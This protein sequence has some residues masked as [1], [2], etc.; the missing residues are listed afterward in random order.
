MNRKIKY[1]LI[2]ASGRLG[3]EVKTVFSEHGHKLVFQFDVKGEKKEDVPEILIDCSLPEVLSKTIFYVNTFSTS[4]I[5]ASTGL[6][7]N[8]FDELRQLSK[9]VPIVQSYN[10]SLGIQVMLKLT[11]IAT[12]KLNDWD[13]EIAETHHRFKKDKPSGTAKMIQE[14]LNKTNVNISS[15]RLGNVPGNHTVSFGGLGEV[16]SI[17]HSATSR[18]TFAEGILKSAEFIQDKDNGFYTFT[19]V[20][21]QK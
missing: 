3:Q 15:L 11:E 7:K 19:D 20:V 10:Y 9:Q 5:I 21:F 16:L 2:G 13:V 6:S 12:T 17:T 18:R 4:L 14:K 8:Q 1:G